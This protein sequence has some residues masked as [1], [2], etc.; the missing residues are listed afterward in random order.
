MGVNLKRKMNS[1]GDVLGQISQSCV[2]SK[3]TENVIIISKMAVSRE[4]LQV[5][6]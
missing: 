1:D 3:K 2:L 5:Q 6:N 4:A